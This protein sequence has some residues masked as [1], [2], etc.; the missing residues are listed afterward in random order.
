MERFLHCAEF[1][2]TEFDKIY[3]DYLDNKANTMDRVHSSPTPARTVDDGK[4]VNI[5][6]IKVEGARRPNMIARYK[7]KK[8][9]RT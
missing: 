1:I 6:I 2:G 9:G 3:C 4:S 8:T 7:K 5:K